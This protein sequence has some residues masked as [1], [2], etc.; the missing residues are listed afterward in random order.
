M[1]ILRSSFNR[2]Q[3]YSQVEI[4]A[5]QATGVVTSV[6]TI[7]TII[8]GKNRPAL[9]NVLITVVGKAVKVGETLAIVDTN[10]AATG[11]V[12]CA[13]SI[14]GDEVTVNGLVYVAVAGAKANDT[15]F[16]IDT[17]DAATA[18]DLADSIDDDVREAPPG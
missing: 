9:S 3:G 2:V 13:T 16:S 15:E 8:N 1:S 6:A 10:E 4:G 17:S 11:T 5:L 12:Q 7:D 14:V 18:T